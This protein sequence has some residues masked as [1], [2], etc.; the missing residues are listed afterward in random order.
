[1][2][3]MSPQ[4][5][6]QYQEA[7]GL[8]ETGDHAG[9]AS[10]LTKLADKHPSHPGTWINLATALYHLGEVDDALE[11][12][13]RAEQ[14]QPDV[15]AVHNLLGLLAQENGEYANAEHHFL[16]ALKLDPESAYAH[17][18]LALLYDLFYQDVAAA[19]PHYEHYLSFSEADDPAT[20]NWVHQLRASL[21]NGG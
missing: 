18:N 20:T 1:M 21:S 6:R 15:P 9:A 8:L 12:V 13:N 10:R 3:M 4:A 7:L 2:A 11:S 19:L 14:L 17:Y 5:L 16:K